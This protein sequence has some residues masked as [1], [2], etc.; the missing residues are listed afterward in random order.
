M[1][2]TSAPNPPWRLKGAARAVTGDAMATT[3][4]PKTTASSDMKTLIS[5]ANRLCLL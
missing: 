3:T 1:L 2:A 4:I 5:I